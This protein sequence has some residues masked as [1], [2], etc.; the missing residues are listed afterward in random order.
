MKIIHIVPLIILIISCGKNSPNPTPNTDST[1]ITQNMLV[2]IWGLDSLIEKKVIM[3]GSSPCIFVNPDGSY[4]PDTTITIRKDDSGYM[5]FSDDNFTV[6]FNW[7]G[8]ETLSYIIIWNGKGIQPN[9][10]NPYTI[11]SLNKRDLVLTG[12]SVGAKSND[13]QPYIYST[14]YLTKK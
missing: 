11:S 3:C 4:K 2:G 14:Y 6:D 1:I 9:G 13:Q 5:Q 7:D 12:Y 8:I 10:R